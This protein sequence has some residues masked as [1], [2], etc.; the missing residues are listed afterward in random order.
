M[1]DRPKHD[2]RLQLPSPA[3]PRGTTMTDSWLVRSPDGVISLPRPEYAKQ[4]EALL[5]DLL[6]KSRGSSLSGP[7]PGDGYFDDH[8]RA[9]YGDGSHD[10]RRLVAR[11]THGGSPKVRETYPIALGTSLDDLISR[12]PPGLSPIAMI[13]NSI[14]APRARGDKSLACVPITP[15]VVVLQTL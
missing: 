5:T 6:W 4:T 3:T 9:R 7:A 8:A 2:W 15:D 1:G 12:V 14:L 13:L 10:M 11:R